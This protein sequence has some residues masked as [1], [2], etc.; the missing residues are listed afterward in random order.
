MDRAVIKEA[1]LTDAL[2]LR[3]VLTESDLDGAIVT[4]ADFSDALIDEVRS[5]AHA[6]K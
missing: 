2:L 3:V 6:L 4:G 5:K 1:N